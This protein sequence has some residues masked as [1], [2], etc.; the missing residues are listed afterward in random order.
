MKHYCKTEFSDIMSISSVVTAMRVCLGGDEPTPDV[1]DFWEI[2]HVC[3][4]EF[5]VTIDGV[6]HELSRGEC[7]IYPPL[8]LHK[9][10]MPQHA[11]L[12]IVSFETDS[13]IPRVLAGVPIRLSE[14]EISLFKE[15]TELG[16]MSLMRPAESGTQLGG[17]VVREG[18]FPPT[19]EILK[20][21]IELMFLEI[22]A[23]RLNDTLKNSLKKYK[24]ELV[25]SLNDYF[26]MNINKAL[27]LEEISR[28][29]SVSVSRLKEISREALGVSP[30]SYF[31][32]LKID[33]AK[34]L[35]RE[36]SLSFTEIAERLGFSSV[37]YFSKLFR[38][39]VGMTPSEFA[40]TF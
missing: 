2:V 11:T 22:Y 14:Y 4:G 18:V 30:I 3:D 26:R 27:T 34:R 36:S 31:I 7:I 40:K 29:L 1:H 17:M 38:K 13:E 21:K 16:G 15:I 8:S 9:G 35:I 28:A 39:K 25:S 6:L 5:K 20:K 37:H 24:R 10:A 12:D 19:L 23:H 33:A 32:D